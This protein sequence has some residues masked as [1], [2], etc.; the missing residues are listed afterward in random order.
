MRLGAGRPSGQ[1]APRGLQ[2][3]IASDS[4]SLDAQ[5]ARGSRATG[6]EPRRLMDVD[7]LERFGF[8]GF[9]FIS[10]HIKLP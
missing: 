9:Q 6:Q 3:A 5:R 7:N 10:Q 1:P 2:S 8:Q 4:R